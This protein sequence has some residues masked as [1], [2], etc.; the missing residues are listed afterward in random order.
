MSKAGDPRWLLLCW[1]PWDRWDGEE[2]GGATKDDGEDTDGT[3]LPRKLLDPFA[4]ARIVCGMVFRQETLERLVLDS[5]NL[6]MNCCTM[7]R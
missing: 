3:R 1:G 2:D 4:F 5:M 7:F 6:Y